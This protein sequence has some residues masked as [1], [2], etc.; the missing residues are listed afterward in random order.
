M[1]LMNKAFMLIRKND[2][3]RITKPTQQYYEQASDRLLFRSLTLDD[4]ALWI[5]F[6]ERDD[7]MRFLGQD[8]DEPAAERSKIWIERQIQRKNDGHYGQLAVIEKSTGNFIGV[9]GIIQRD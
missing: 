2:G 1:P 8:I 3:M 6:F 4:I 7:Y 5:P 9:G